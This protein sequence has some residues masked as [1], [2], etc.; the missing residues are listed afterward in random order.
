MNKKCIFLL[1]IGFMAY[2]GDIMAQ[3]LIITNVNGN[4]GQE[5]ILV[6][7]TRLE[8]Y[9]QFNYSSKITLFDGESF[10]YQY[11]SPRVNGSKTITFR[12]FQKAINSSANP[13]TLSLAEYYQKLKNKNS[14][15][16]K[17]QTTQGTTIPVWT[18]VDDDRQNSHYPKDPSKIALIIG[19]EKYQHKEWLITSRNSAYDI[20][21]SLRSIGFNTL[22]IVD[23]GYDNLSSALQF[24]YGASQDYETKLFYYV[25]H[26]TSDVINDY[27][28]P[29]DATGNCLDSC[30]SITSIAKNMQSGNKTKTRLLFFDACRT[31]E[32]RD[33]S[34]DYEP[35]AGAVIMYS[36]GRNY[37][38]YPYANKNDKYTIFSQGVLRN[39]TLK[40]NL[41][42]VL[43]KIQSYTKSAAK[44]AHLTQNPEIKPYETKT[45]DIYLNTN[46]SYVR[47]GLN[48]T[49]LNN[50]NGTNS[51][52][53]S[54]NDVNSFGYW[55]ASVGFLYGSVCLGGQLD[56]SKGWFGLAELGWSVH[57]GGK[58]DEVYLYNTFDVAEYGYT[59][60]PNRFLCP[61]LHIGVGYNFTDNFSLSLLYGASYLGVKG[62]PIAGYESNKGDKAAVICHSPNLRAVWTPCTSKPWKVQLTIGYDIAKGDDN[63]DVLKDI[64]Q[65][66]SM[67]EGF[68]C[69]IGFIRKF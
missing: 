12:D 62:T 19:N 65:I 2:H 52:G 36:C 11:V 39:I 20:G 49:N 26:G 22:V 55:G 23:E 4:Q 46:K 27:I 14:S 13:I 25:G 30:F 34:V 38:S 32:H 53:V 21:D 3:T 54:S 28:I 33:V 56:L 6:G 67:A 5:S 66:K 35:G 7:E 16:L 60:C 9:K 42:T 17:T 57:L 44:T 68:R 51:I 47:P 59:Y 1:F 40:S 18:F 41:S 15:S 43:D 50:N 8:K 64:D 10:S 69:Q 31:V 29:T 45:N 48:G 24:F 61:N 63:Y 37:E 58:S